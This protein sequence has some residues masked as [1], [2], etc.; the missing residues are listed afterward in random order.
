MPLLDTVFRELNAVGIT[1]KTKPSPTGTPAS[2][3]E[4]RAQLSTWARIPSREEVPKQTE[5]CFLG[6]T[7]E[8]ARNR[9]VPRPS[10]CT[11]PFPSPSSSGGDRIAEIPGQRSQNAEQRRDSSVRRLEL[12]AHLWPHEMARRRACARNELRIGGSCRPRVCCRIAEA[13]RAVR[14]VLE[15]K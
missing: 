3:Q 13:T 14:R 4:S 6:R 1:R 12:K 7:R 15:R 10:S 2:A 11:N 9:R 8:V 5:P